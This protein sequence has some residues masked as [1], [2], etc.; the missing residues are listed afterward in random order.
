MKLILSAHCIEKQVDI[1]ELI[2]FTRHGL[3]IR[4]SGEPSLKSENI[5]Q[6]REDFLTEMRKSPDLRESPRLNDNFLI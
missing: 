5:V 3:Q 6:K 1:P 2:M 4:A